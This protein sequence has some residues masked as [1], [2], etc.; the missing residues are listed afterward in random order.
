M[1]HLCNIG[2]GE[3]WSDT[4]AITYEQKPGNDRMAVYG[5]STYMTDGG[6]IRQYPYSSDR[7]VAKQ[8]YSEV[9]GLGNHAM[10]CIW[11]AFLFVRS[12]NNAVFV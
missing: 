2:L 4:L 10:G 1:L 9:P 3:G 12:L 11:N 6:T 8:R 5:M 7:E